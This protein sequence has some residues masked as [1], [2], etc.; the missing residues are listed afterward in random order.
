[1]VEVYTRVIVVMVSVLL[2]SWGSFANF[3][4]AYATSSLDKLRT[5]LD[6]FDIEYGKHSGTPLADKLEDARNL[7]LS[8]LE[9]LEKD[10]PDVI[11]AIA[12]ISEAQKEIQVAIDVEGFSPLIGKIMIKG[13]DLFKDK[14]Y[15][16][17]NTIPVI[18]KIEQKGLEIIVTWKQDTNA[19]GDLP[20]KHDLDMSIDLPISKSKNC[21]KEW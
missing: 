9:E 6:D 5:L 10:P 13:L 16:S 17:L 14:L 8:A 18:T 12:N 7:F 1:M 19:F 20:D 11:S 3:T 21:C 4:P 2:L 15:D